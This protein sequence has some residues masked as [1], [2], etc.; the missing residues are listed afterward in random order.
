MLSGPRKVLG[1]FTS[2]LSK[3]ANVVNGMMLHSP[4][5]V[6]KAKKKAKINF[7]IRKLLPK[8]IKPEDIPKWI[9]A[10]LHA[11]P[12]QSLALWADGA[13]QLRVAAKQA[14]TILHFHLPQYKVQ[15]DHHIQDAN[16]EVSLEDILHAQPETKPLIRRPL[17]KTDDLEKLK[18]QIHLAQ[19]CVTQE[20]ITQTKDKAQTS[21]HNLESSG[22]CGICLD[23]YN[24][25]HPPYLVKNTNSVYHKDCLESYAKAKR[26]GDRHCEIRD[27]ASNQLLVR[28]NELLDIASLMCLDKAYLTAVSDAT[29]LEQRTKELVKML[30]ILAKENEEL[31]KHSQRAEVA[32]EQPVPP[33]TQKLPTLDTSRP[34][35]TK[36][37][38]RH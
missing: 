23:S 38:R 28:Y 22:Q 6:A 27:P 8:E 20:M 31:K 4:P 18:F 32:P 33:V 7:D 16:G 24:N 10:Y 25:E 21:I 13:L 37:Y 15:A 1:F 12:E 3:V 17:A 30:D 11:L 35:K 26:R 29:T 9:E 36:Q 34:R 19:K 2:A 14:D 5:I